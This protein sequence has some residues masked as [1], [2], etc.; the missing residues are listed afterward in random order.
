MMVH[1]FLFEAKVDIWH[2]NS[3]GVYSGVQDAGTGQNNFLR[4][5]QMTDGNGTVQFTT[6]YPGWYVAE[7]VHGGH[8]DRDG[9]IGQ[10]AEVFSLIKQ[11]IMIITAYIWPNYFRIDIISVASCLYLI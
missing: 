7:D 3:Q 11:E 6:I 10:L 1:A 8:K 9:I 4:G 2:A 5:Y